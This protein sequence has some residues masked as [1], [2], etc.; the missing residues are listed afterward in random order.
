VKLA[1]P[2]G[3]LETHVGLHSRGGDV[4]GD[5]TLVLDLPHYG[6][7]DLQVTA[8]ELDLSHWLGRRAPPSRLNFTV[9][10]GFSGDSAGAP[11]GSVQ[12]TL[13]PSR[14]AGAGLDSGAVRVRF[15]DR[16]LYVDSLRIAQSGLITTGSGSLGWMRGVRGQLA[17]DFDADSLNALDPLLG[18]LTGGAPDAPTDP[19][20]EVA[21]NAPLAGSARVLLRLEGSLD[22]LALDAR[23]SVERLA[24]RAWRVAG[25][26]GALHLAAGSRPDVRAG[27]DPGFDRPRRVSG[28]P[29]RRPRRAGPAIRSPG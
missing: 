18:W 14:L 22:S 26:P 13:E 12:A 4:L 16:R 24:W 6:A 27:R 8:H 28:F 10:G 11:L 9:K 29:A 1:G 7:R 15:A 23:A 19:G 21:V 3:S 20:E 5:G 2:L 25:R 17:L